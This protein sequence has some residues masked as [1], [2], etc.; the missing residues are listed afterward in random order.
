MLWDVVISLLSFMCTQ[1]G[2]HSR[3][4]PSVLLC[5]EGISLDL[6]ITILLFD[7][8]ELRN[9]LRAVNAK[10]SYWK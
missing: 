3:N 5:A 10:E 9:G 6:E 4:G 1:G 7:Y 8:R 2:I